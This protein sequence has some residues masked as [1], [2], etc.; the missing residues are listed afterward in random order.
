MWVVAGRRRG[1]LH[2]K[3]SLFVVV[4]VVVEDE[5]FFRCRDQIICVFLFTRWL[6]KQRS[7]PSPSLPI[8]MAAAPENLHAVK[9]S[10][11]FQELLK[12]DLNRVSLISFWA[13]WAEPC[14]RMNDVVTE[15]AKKHPKLLVLT[16]GS[17]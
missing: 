8:A 2:Q 6:C 16:V 3:L 7:T 12:Q 10:G 11:H 1:R 13:D 9:S 4:V 17:S 15:L 14:K 5:R